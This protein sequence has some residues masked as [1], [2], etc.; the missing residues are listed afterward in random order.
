MGK[1]SKK[2]KCFISYAWNPNPQDN[3]VLQAKLT[4]L[5]GDLMR[6]GME[7]L[8]DLDN[9]EGHIETYMKKGIEGSDRVLLI[10]LCYCNMILR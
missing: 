7:V 4:K 8:F 6:A 9:M 3:A 10:S 5:K 2:I 1:Q